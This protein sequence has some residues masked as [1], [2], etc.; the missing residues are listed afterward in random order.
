[1]SFRIGHLLAT[2]FA[3]LVIAALVI[4]APASASVV[5]HVGAGAVQPDENLLFNQPGLTSTGT[6][7]EGATNRD[8]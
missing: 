6:T 1:M 8:A 2:G 5:F 7:V 3:A 4:A